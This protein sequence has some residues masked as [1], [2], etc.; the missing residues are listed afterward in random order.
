MK[1]GNESERQRGKTMKGEGDLVVPR[2]PSWHGAEGVIL[3]VKD[4][5]ELCPVITPRE[6]LCNGSLQCLAQVGTEH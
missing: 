5:V 3:L 4:Q 1:G 2:R 6:C